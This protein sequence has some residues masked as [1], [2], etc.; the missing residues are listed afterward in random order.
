M[1]F[2]E[3]GMSKKG[4]DDGEHERRGVLVPWLEKGEAYG[5]ARSDR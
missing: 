2:I 3:K 1:S 4:E 5:F